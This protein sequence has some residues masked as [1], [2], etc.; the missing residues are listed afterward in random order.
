MSEENQG[1]ENTTPET[2]AVETQEGPPKP[3]PPQWEYRTQMKVTGRLT[4]VV[5]LSID[6]SKAE[7]NRLRRQLEKLT[8]GS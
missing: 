1:G 7:V 5:K 2:P 6:V 3:P 4:E 8:Y